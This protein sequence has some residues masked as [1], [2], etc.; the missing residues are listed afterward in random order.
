M[1]RFPLGSLVS[2][3]HHADSGNTLSES[4]GPSGLELHRRRSEGP[5][6]ILLPAIPSSMD[7]CNTR[8]S[9]EAQKVSVQI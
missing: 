8:F 9:A 7:R 5:W 6:T 4:E 2:L 1:H 3:S